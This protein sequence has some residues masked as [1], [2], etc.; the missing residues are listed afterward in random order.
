L[1]L[2]RFL[3]WVKTVYSAMEIHLDRYKR[4]RSICPGGWMSFGSAAGVFAG[5]CPAS[6]E[7]WDKRYSAPG[8]SKTCPDAREFF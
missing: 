8:G 2:R 4:G 7:R 5:N 1:T 3:G 6:R